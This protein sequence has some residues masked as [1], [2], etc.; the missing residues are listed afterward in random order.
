MI[1]FTSLR[2]T[3]VDSQIRPNDVT[4]RR[5]LK[6]MLEVPREPFVAPS[7]REVAYMDEAVPVE[8]GVP[9]TTA[10]RLPAPVIVARMLQA[11]ELTARDVVLEVGCATGYMSAVASR[12]ALRVVGL[13]VDP[14]LAERG[15]RVLA[16][17]AIDN[18]TLATG[19]LA[20]GMPANG[21]YDIIVCNGSLPEVPQALLDQLK[22][23]GRLV[24]VIGEG[25][26]GHAVLLER[27]G[28]GWAG[29]P[30]FDA[31]APPLPGFER[32]TVF[33]L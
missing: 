7:C 28:K 29:R 15:R 14:R 19:P 4:D 33:A 16:Q 2:Q 6:A 20:E 21:P 3:M 30:I 23:S 11:A 13:E 8:E 10:R 24:A 5:I 12:L 26:L 25:P 18:V 22:P 31:S 17:L 32:P 9:P 27:G 1:D